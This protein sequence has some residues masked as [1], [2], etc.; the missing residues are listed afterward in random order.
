MRRHKPFH[1]HRRR[2]KS[3]SEQNQERT[4]PYRSRSGVLLGVIKGLAEYFNLSVFWCRVVAV[5][6]LLF[7]GVWPIVGLYL[8]AALL[9]KLEPVVE[10]TDETDHE[11]YNS[12]TTSRKMAVHRLKRTFDRLERRLRRV[13]DRVTAKE[14]DWER[15]FYEGQ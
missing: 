12:Y 6:F 5:G 3:D 7:T 9:M 10:F 14:Y 15:R 11:F 8:L 13:E 2:S 4:G 1:S